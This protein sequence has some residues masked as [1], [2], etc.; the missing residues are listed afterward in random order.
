MQ[1]KGEGICAWSNEEECAARLGKLIIF[2]RWDL[3][4][5]LS[6]CKLHGRVIIN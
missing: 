1:I 6:F 4:I 3:G 2:L 5:M